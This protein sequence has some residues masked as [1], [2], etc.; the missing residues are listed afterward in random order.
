LVREGLGHLRE[1][2]LVFLPA[3]IKNID[4]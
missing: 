2:L 4:L 1:T 3:N